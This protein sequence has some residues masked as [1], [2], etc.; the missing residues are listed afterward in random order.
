MGTVY[1]VNELCELEQD[2]YMNCH[3]AFVDQTEAYQ[4]ANELY[5][6]AKQDIGGEWCES[7]LKVWNDNNIITIS[8]DKV[9]LFTK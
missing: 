2:N 8:V 9:D 3:G 6:Q 4:F 1:V 7:D 5:E